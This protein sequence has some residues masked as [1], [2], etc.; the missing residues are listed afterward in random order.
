LNYLG[1]EN[2][3]IKQRQM[4]PELT[5]DDWVQNAYMMTAND[6]IANPYLQSDEVLRNLLKQ[7]VGPKTDL[8]TIVTAD[9]TKEKI[10]MKQLRARMKQAAPEQETPRAAKRPKNATAPPPV[11]SHQTGATTDDELRRQRVLDCMMNTAVSGGT[12][13]TPVHNGYH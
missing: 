3:L 2:N 12:P 7:I 13:S 1:F 8:V 4:F 9:G 10:S 11:A 6:L 5:H